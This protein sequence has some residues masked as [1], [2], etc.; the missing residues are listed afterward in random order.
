MGLQQRAV[1]VKLAPQISP[2][3]NPSETFQTRIPMFSALEFLGRESLVIQRRVATPR[4]LAD[5][6]NSS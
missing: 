6:Q 5:N 1:D 2:P 3:R 4:D